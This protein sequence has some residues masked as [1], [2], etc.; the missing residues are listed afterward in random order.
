L[1]GVAFHGEISLKL[2][3][4]WVFGRGRLLFWRRSRFLFRR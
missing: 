1:R 3:L 2:S 4:V